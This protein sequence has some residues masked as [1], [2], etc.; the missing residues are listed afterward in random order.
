[1]NYPIEARNMDLTPDEFFETYTIGSKL[2]E[3]QFGTVH[4]IMNKKS[5]VEHAVKIMKLPKDS[6]KK[7]RFYEWGTGFGISHH[8]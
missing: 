7:S 5:N 3:G 6:E 2:G 4:K 8:E 1:M